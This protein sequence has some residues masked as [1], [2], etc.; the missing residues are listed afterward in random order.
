MSAINRTA[1][2]KYD[3]HLHISKSQMYFICMHSKRKNIRICK[4][5]AAFSGVPRSITRENLQKLTFKF[6][7]VHEIFLLQ[8]KTRRH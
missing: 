1:K 2:S 6:D 5:V 4:Y 7:K 3:A 8:F